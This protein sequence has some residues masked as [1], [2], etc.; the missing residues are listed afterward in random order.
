MND[1]LVWCLERC[2]ISDDTTLHKLFISKFYV[3]SYNDIFVFI[4]KRQLI[5]FRQ[6]SDLLQIDAT[7]RLNWNDLPVLVFGCSD[8]RRRFYP[9]GIASVGTDEATSSYIVLFKT[10]KQTVLDIT[11]K[12]F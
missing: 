7:F 10:I 5:F 2:R 9:C 4:T 8:A 1:L 12:I 3:N 6:L 11:G